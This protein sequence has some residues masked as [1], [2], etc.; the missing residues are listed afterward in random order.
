[1]WIKYPAMESRNWK[2]MIPAIPREPKK[3]KTRPAI[4]TGVQYSSTRNAVNDSLGSLLRPAFQHPITDSNIEG[5][6]WM[7]I[8]QQSNKAKVGNSID[9]YAHCSNIVDEI[10][11]AG[12]LPKPSKTLKLTLKIDSSGIKEETEVLNGG[13]PLRIMKVLP[14]ISSLN[15]QKML[16][17]N[18]TTKINTRPVELV[19]KVK[20]ND[21]KT[22]KQVRMAI[23]SKIAVAFVNEVLR[24]GII[25]NCFI[26]NSIRKTNES[27]N[28]SAAK[29]THFIRSSR[30]RK[31]CKVI[32]EEGKRLLRHNRFVD[33]LTNDQSRL[34][35]ARRKIQ[36]DQQITNWWLNRQEKKER[37]RISDRRNLHLLT[38]P[39]YATAEASLQGQD[40][41][42]GVMLSEEEMSGQTAP[43]VMTA[44][45]KALLSL[46]QMDAQEIQ[47]WREKSA[48]LLH[49]TR[50]QHFPFPSI[51]PKN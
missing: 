12:R 10:V 42:K 13:S 36:E 19:N 7:S 39:I 14:Q 1:M 45:R 37:S 3:S 25:N 20:I 4:P 49:F 5:K 50:A 48:H 29:I 11:T 17:E 18:G 32:L 41:E 2:Q 9:Q 6:M 44:A 26:T 51:S 31:F 15:A 24:S 34:R 40:W 47:R 43:V 46:C 27:K 8:V 21:S 33:L 35:N 30:Q 38:E 22:K 23:T 28:I 16:K